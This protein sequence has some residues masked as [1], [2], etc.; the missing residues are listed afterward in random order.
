MKV[1][2]ARNRSFITIGL[3]L[4]LGWMTLAAQT[5]EEPGLQPAGRDDFALAWW[6]DEAEELPPM[7]PMMHPGQPGGPW[8][9]H[10]PRQTSMVRMWKLTEYLELSEQQAEK[11]FPRARG[12]RDEMQKIGEQRRELHQQFVK[13]IEGGK[14]SRRDTK[15]FIDQL[16]RLD[17]A[18][19]DLRRKH[20]TGA[21]DVLTVVQQAKYAT[22]D[23]HFMGQLRRRL[24][25]R[26]I[27]REMKGKAFK[28]KRDYRRDTPRIRR[29]LR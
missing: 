10:S 9:Q 5:I 22:F 28:R 29:F 2:I 6:Q 23:E 1:N 8:P 3:M 16:H 19:L 25:D 21:E 24:G 18:R 27:R 12:H 26:D 13:K 15:K 20:M 11:F 17:L 4:L 14:V 7:G